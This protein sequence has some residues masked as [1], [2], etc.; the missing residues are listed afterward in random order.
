MGLSFG[1]VSLNSKSR[2]G[3]NLSNFSLGSPSQDE[4]KVVV[5]VSN[6]KACLSLFK[7]ATTVSV[8]LSDNMVSFSSGS[9]TALVAGRG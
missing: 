3:S 4:T 1:G 8:G 7:K 5:S 6:L 2:D 9:V